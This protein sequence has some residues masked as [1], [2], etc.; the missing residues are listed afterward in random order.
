MF[1]IA[2][3]QVPRLLKLKQYRELVFFLGM[4]IIAGVYALL[5]VMDFPLIS[6]FEIIARVVSVVMTKLGLKI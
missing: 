2:F 6:P 3:W 4:W 1:I 5:V